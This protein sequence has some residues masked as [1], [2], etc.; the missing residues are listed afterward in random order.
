MPDEREALAMLRE[1]PEYDWLT[2]SDAPWWT[3]E[4]VASHTGVSEETVRSRAK[5]GEIPGAIQ[6]DRPVGWRL[7]RSGLL[8]FYSER[9]RRQQQSAG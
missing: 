9:Y 2:G 5:G 8:A 3:V 6:Y 7:P 1:I 4:Q